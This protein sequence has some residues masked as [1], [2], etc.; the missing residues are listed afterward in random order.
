M[1]YLSDTFYV[2]YDVK[3]YANLKMHLSP[4][5]FIHPISR[6]PLHQLWPVMVTIPLTRGD[7]YSLLHHNVLFFT[8]MTF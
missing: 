8:I 7:S 3:L 5:S 4:N 2:T 1:Y 6:A